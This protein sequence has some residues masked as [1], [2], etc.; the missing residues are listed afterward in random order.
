MKFTPLAL[1]A[2]F[3]IVGTSAAD[4]SSG[5]SSSSCGS[6][7]SKVSDL[8]CGSDGITYL[9][10]CELDNAKCVKGAK[11]KVLHGGMCRRD[12]IGE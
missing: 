5:S 9:N 6:E 12:E 11:L 3:A 4:S 7:C 10:S 8:V 2:A 1:I